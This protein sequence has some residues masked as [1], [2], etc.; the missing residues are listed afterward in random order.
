[1]LLGQ[2][3]FAEMNALSP[4]SRFILILRDPVE[5]ILSAARMYINILQDNQTP[6]QVVFDTLNG[7]EPLHLLHSDYHR[8]L[9]AL[10]NEVDSNRIAVF[11]YET[12]FQQSEIDK[13]CSF[14]GVP[15]HPA[16]F[17]KI[18]NGSDRLTDNVPLEL[19]KQLAQ[20]LSPTYEF[21]FSRFCD[22]VPDLWK[23]NAE[24]AQS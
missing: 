10:D 17:S 2:N 13:L 14:L 11:F 15:S 5:R 23:R 12:L 8:P 4:N 22:A 20:S 3:T 18:V 6:K 7:A 9:T 24:L 19:K 1:M 21:V 16:E